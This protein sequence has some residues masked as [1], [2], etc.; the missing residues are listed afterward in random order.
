MEGEYEECEKYRLAHLYVN[1]SEA[2][3]CGFCK[4]GGN[5]DEEGKGF[6]EEHD[7]VNVPLTH[8]VWF[9]GAFLI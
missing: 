1:E 9:N 2:A 5:P 3:K 4:E 7:W 6:L 8:E